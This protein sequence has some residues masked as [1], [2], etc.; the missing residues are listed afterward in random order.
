MAIS[1]VCVFCAASPNLDEKFVIEAQKLGYF[2]AHEGMELVYGGGGSGLMGAVS[3]AVMEKK[4]H[5]LGF[6]P[7][8]LMA[9]EDASS[10]ITR[11][12]IV[13]DMHERKKSMYKHADAFV[14]LPGGFGTFDELC[15]VVTWRNLG[16][17][18]K[19]VIIV[20]LE[21]YW[22]H[23]KLQIEK[24]IAERII[25]ESYRSSFTF[26]STVEECFAILKNTTITANDDE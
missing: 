16:F 7:Q 1:S 4:G 23:F 3:D 11:L 26:V 14:V 12:T 9:L 15:E 8:D 19:P 21:G 17:H 18:K 2:L 20:D 24:G 13:H 10:R 25:S 6:M 22:T 5:V